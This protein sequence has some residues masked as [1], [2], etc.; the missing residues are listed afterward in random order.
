MLQDLLETT[1][2]V[3]VHIPVGRPLRHE[4]WCVPMED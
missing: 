1:S 3:M 4:D 2:G